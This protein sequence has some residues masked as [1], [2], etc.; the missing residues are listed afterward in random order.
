[1]NAGK[2]S[3]KYPHARERPSAYGPLGKSFRS[4]LETWLTILG[5]IV[6]T[7]ALVIH[8]GRKVDD[9]EK[10]DRHIMSHLGE[11][12]DRFDHLRSECN[13]NTDTIRRLQDEINRLKRRSNETK[14]DEGVRKAGNRVQ[15]PRKRARG[16]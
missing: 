8:L 7:A 4:A 15:K 5:A 11:L 2:T 13:K 6:R 9:A 12:D 1:M 3:T 16:A 14:G 10:R